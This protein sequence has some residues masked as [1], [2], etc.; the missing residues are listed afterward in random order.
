M[1]K[2]ILVTISPLEMAKKNDDDLK[3]AEYLGG[4]RCTV[5]FCVV[6]REWYL[7]Q[8]ECGIPYKESKRSWVGKDEQRVIY[9]EDV[10]CRFSQT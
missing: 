5:T 2:D 1:I 3:H 9:Q 4:L 10:T 8:Q 7:H 6:N